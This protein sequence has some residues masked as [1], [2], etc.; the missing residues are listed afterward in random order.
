M[1]ADGWK[2]ADEWRQLASGVGPTLVGGSKKH[3]GADLGPTRAKEGWKRLFVD[4]RGVADAPPSANA[5]SSKEVA[6]RLTIEMTARVQGWRAEDAWAFAGRKTSQYRQIGNA[7][8]PPVA[9]AI[10]AQIIAALRHEGELRRDPPQSVDLHDPVYKALASSP[11]PLTF[12]DLVR[13]HNELASAVVEQR[14]AALR[15]DFE[16]ETIEGS[17]GVLRYR[18]GS[19]K[20]FTGQKDHSRHE[21]FVQ[22]RNRVS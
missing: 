19:F 12:D 22:H 14:L 17:D 5:P 3:G 2:Y 11:V 10:G 7:F 21:F 9:H 20:G 4:G 1:A 8:P 16:L 13:A 18:L 6:P 15:Q